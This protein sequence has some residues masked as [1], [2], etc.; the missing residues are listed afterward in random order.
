VS[1]ILQK[2]VILIQ[3]LHSN[4]QRNNP[5]SFSSEQM[6]RVD[7]DALMSSS[8]TE[9]SRNIAKLAERRTDIFGVGSQGAEQTII[10]KKLGEEESSGPPRPDPRNIWDGQQSTIDATTRFAQQ[11]AQ[12]ERLAASVAST[13]TPANFIPPPPVNRIPATLGGSLLTSAP[14]PI[15]AASFS[16]PAPSSAFAEGW[17]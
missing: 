4:N 3:P 15:D 5:L 16:A 12:Q 7:D 9:I 1:F 10:G 2:L 6:D 13:N 8:G 11:Q 14:A 17:F